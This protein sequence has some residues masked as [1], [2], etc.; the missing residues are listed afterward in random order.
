MPPGVAARVRFDPPLPADRAEL[1]SSMPGGGMIKVLT[2]YNDSFWRADGLTGQSVAMH[3]PIEMTLDAS[4]KSGTPGILASFAFGPFPRDLARMA[5]AERRALVLDTLRRRFGEPAGEPLH[6]QEHDW[7]QEEWT[8]GCSM[9][10]FAPGEFMRNAPVLRRPTG[11]IH[12]AGSET[13]TVSHGAIDG[14][15]RSGERA[16]AE[17]LAA[18]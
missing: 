14:A 1:L 9:G 12:W 8:S 11:R 4:T 3:S 5:P 13:A 18:S 16:A 10:H 7:E 17:V 6:Y 15:I 2:V